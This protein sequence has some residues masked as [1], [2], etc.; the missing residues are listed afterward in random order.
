MRYVN[1]CQSDQQ[2]AIRIK[3]I[4]EALDACIETLDRAFLVVDGIDRCSPAVKLENE[5]PRLRAKGLKVLT[6]S[7]IPSLQIPW[8]Q[9]YCDA[10]PDTE[11]DV[12]RF[13]YWLCQRP[14]CLTDLT[15][16]C[17]KCKEENKG[18]SIW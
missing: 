8:M 6:T 12:E 1:A 5:L 15:T 9:F 11:Q 13:V 16:I 3:L 4:R 14:E 10:C 7:R 18:C 17:V 2:G